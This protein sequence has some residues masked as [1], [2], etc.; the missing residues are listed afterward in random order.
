MSWTPIDLNP[1]RRIIFAPFHLR[2]QTTTHI[3]HVWLAAYLNNYLLCVWLSPVIFELTS[4]PTFFSGHFLNNLTPKITVDIHK[5]FINYQTWRL[6]Y[7][8]RHRWNITCHF[9]RT[10]GRLLSLH[11]CHGTW[12]VQMANGSWINKLL[13]NIEQTD[14]FW[15]CKLLRNY[16]FNHFHLGKHHH[17]R[18]LVKLSNIIPLKSTRSCKDM[19]ALRQEVMWGYESP[20]TAS[21]NF[22]QR[23][24]CVIRRI[25][26]QTTEF[27]LNI[28][29]T[30]TIATTNID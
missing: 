5:L 12:H 19:H 1:V 21:R 15:G 8:C 9:P 10:G 25:K 6:Q 30:S 13:S 3:L 16:R 4:N 28:N 27:R 24:S 11:G 17:T 20:K 2:R 18:S 26:L 7:S 22:P 29:E 14:T 23:D